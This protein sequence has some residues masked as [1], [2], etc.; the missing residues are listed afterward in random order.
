[1]KVSFM[2]KYALLLT[3][4]LLSAQMYYSF[5]NIEMN[6]LQWSSSTKEQTTQKDFAYLSLEGGAGWDFGELYVLSSIE[7]P[8]KNYNA[9]PNNNL[10]FSNL[11]DFDVNIKNGFRLHFQDFTLKGKTFYVNNFVAG[12]GYKYQK[13]NI[14]WIRPFVGVHRVDDTYFN[15]LNGYMTGWSF[16]YNFSFQEENFALFQWNE[17][18]FLREKSF[19][20]LSDGT[21]IGDGASYGLN[22][23][24]SLWWFTNQALTLGVQ[25]RYAKNKLGSSAAQNGI[26]S[27]LKYNF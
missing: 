12:L 24:V 11:V 14:F 3:P 19:Y 9:T 20:Q 10:R 23:A 22:G 16:N 26:I 8:T 27:T 5:S 17:V 4:T 18:E 7:N 2:N 6:Y 1:M 25:Y 13:E 21:P 15:G